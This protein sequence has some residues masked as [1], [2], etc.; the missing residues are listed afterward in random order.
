MLH[1]LPARLPHSTP[2][3]SS[4]PPPNLFSSR[5]SAV[6][7]GRACPYENSLPEAGE[8]AGSGNRSFTA[9][10]FFHP[11]L[12]LGRL[13]SPRRALSSTR[14]HANQESTSFVHSSAAVIRSLL[15]ARTIRLARSHLTLRAPQRGVARAR[16]ASDATMAG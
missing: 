5:R 7:G 6:R 15:Y 10:R 9:I 8:F 12:N 1:S 14:S 13:A 11:A 4:V 2:C 16:S 3:P